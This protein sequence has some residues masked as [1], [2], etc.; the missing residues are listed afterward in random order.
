MQEKAILVLRICAW[1]DLAIGFL[2]V[3]NTQDKV[4]LIIYAAAIV[5]IWA[6]LLVVCLIAE[7]LIE[8]RAQTAPAAKTQL[9]DRE[10]R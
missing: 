9:F 2:T 5:T 4:L 10:A 6:F 1:L 7:S 3:V 8:I